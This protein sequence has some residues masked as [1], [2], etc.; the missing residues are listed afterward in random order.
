MTLRRVSS[1]LPN[2][3]WAA[4][5]I[6]MTKGEITKIRN[7]KVKSFM[8]YNLIRTSSTLKTHATC[9]LSFTFFV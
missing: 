1:Y 3:L 2:G 9:N 6:T 8:G 7:D 5:W 4:W